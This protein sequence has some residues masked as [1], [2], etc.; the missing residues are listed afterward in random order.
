MFLQWHS[1]RPPLYNLFEFKYMD[2][3]LNFDARLDLNDFLD[4][5]A[6]FVFLLLSQYSKPLS[7]NLACPRLHLLDLSQTLR[8]C[9]HWALF[10]HTR[11]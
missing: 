1:Q 5:E 4:F 2:D 11:H 7:C 10:S 6:F 9:K 8:T 3:L